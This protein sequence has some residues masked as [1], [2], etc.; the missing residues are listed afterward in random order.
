MT[1]NRDLLI[2]GADLVGNG[3]N[4]LLIRDGI[5]IAAG[6]QAQDE[7]HD[8]RIIDAEGLIALPGLVDI[9][10]HLRQPGQEDAETVFT[11]TRSAAVGGYTAVHAMANT[12]PVADT[13][14]VVDQVLELGQEAGW[15]QVRPVGAVTVGLEGKQLS[16]MGAMA[17]SRSQVRVFSDDGKCVADPVLM[18]R[19]LE[20]VKAFDAVVAQHAQDPV[21][22][23]GAQ[24]N[25]SALSGEL[26][27]AGWPAVAEEAII[28]R[29]I[30][31]AK[32]VGSRLHVC[33]LS[34]AGSVDIVR[35]G[36]KMGVNVTAEV[37]PHHLLLTEELARSYDPI[38]KVNPPLRTAEDV[39]AVREGLADG[40]IDVVGTD[41]APHPLESKD[42][43]W[44][45]G[46]F[47]MTG[48]ETALPVVIETMVNTGRMDW[49]DVARV[50][51]TT[52][53][54]IGRVAG[55]GQALEVGA[56]A[57]LTL[58]DPTVRRVVD[59]RQQ[60][61]R[62]TNSPYKGLELPGRALY[63]IYEGAIT[64]DSGVP[65]EKENR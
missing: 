17:R 26:G 9:H 60:W 41:H 48:L 54:R 15:V 28:A 27:L 53:A 58:V 14:S 46:S 12:N 4:D 10:T 1:E 25:E 31:L 59:P 56:N 45:S 29:D 38:Y 2:R 35:W 52:P 37:T 6:S 30:L 33:H 8:A 24:M 36:K 57:N 11:G 22:T 49:N 64:V 34:T 23:E 47:G 32:H 13:A 39:E 62:S 40:T 3:A 20:Y 50:L 44:Q 19:A 61:T 5:I 55:Q 42:C 65:I 16:A 43:E 7:A 21:L 63:T 18:R 51:S